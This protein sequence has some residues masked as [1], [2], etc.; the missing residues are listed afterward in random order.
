MSDFIA[1]TPL[2]AR[3]YCPS[4]EPGADPEAEILDVLWCDAHRPATKGL[5]DIDPALMTFLPSN[6]EA[7]GDDNRRMCQII[8][9]GKR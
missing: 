5:D 6:V 1:D 2:V 4:C 7:G 3:L 8:H 9:G